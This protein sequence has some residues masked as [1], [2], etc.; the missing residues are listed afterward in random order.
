MMYQEATRTGE[1]VCLFW[2]YPNSQFFTGEI[3]SWQF[4]VLRGILFVDIHLT[5]LSIRSLTLYFR[6]ELFVGFFI[7]LSRRVIICRHLAPPY[8]L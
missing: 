4:Q 1:L 5:G 7:G 8:D 2:N 6:H 3:R